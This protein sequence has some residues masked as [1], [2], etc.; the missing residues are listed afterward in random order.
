MDPIGG[1]SSLSTVNMTTIRVSTNITIV[2]NSSN[3]GKNNNIDL[4]LSVVCMNR[5][6][7]PPN[8][9]KAQLIHTTNSDKRSQVDVIIFPLILNYCV[10]SS[11]TL[12]ISNA[13]TRCY[14]D[15]A[16]RAS[17]GLPVRIHADNR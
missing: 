5:S 16:Q 11:E 14:V 10:R 9:I 17:H 12:T 4:P 6:E 2:Q 13:L 7:S 1:P 8:A 15:G 3:K